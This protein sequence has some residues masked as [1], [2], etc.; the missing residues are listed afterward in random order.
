LK[1]SKSADSSVRLMRAR[2]MWKLVELSP[3][4]RKIENAPE[5][6]CYKEVSTK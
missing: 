4:N 6:V 2:H 1:S 5:K 3:W